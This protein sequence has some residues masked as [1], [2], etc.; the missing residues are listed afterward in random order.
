[1]LNV[2]KYVESSY[3]PKIFIFVSVISRKENYASL[4]KDENSQNRICSDEDKIDK[5]DPVL[6]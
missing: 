3:S 1:M 5:I 2:L 6:F 4:T